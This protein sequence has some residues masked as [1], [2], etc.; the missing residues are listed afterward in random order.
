M[1]VNSDIEEMFVA[2]F[3]A[4]DNRERWLTLLSSEKGRGKILDRLSHTFSKDLD[5]R[6]AYDKDTPPPNVATQ[7][8]QVLSPWIA[9]NPKKLCYIIAN[10][11]EV[12][13]QTMS[14]SEA[15]ADSRLTAGAIIILIPD[16]LAY[17]HT[18]RSN[19]NKQPYYV[20][21]RP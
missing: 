11:G 12:D 19:L 1:N 17:Y 10:N 7:V 9:G 6:F 4:R 21:F 20:L 18:E 13:G 15:E 8:K 14:L 16:K 5:P 2:S 3:I